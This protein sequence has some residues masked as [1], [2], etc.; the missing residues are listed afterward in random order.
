MKITQ[1]QL[2]KIIKEEVEE[3]MKEYGSDKRSIPKQAWLKAISD[4][5]MTDQNHRPIGEQTLN[6]YGYYYQPNR[7]IG[8]SRWTGA[9]YKPYDAM[10]DSGGIYAENWADKAIKAAMEMSG[11]VVE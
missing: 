11:D 10:A 8:D 2:R 3:T 9:F 6:N 7:D 4:A 5:N 1:K